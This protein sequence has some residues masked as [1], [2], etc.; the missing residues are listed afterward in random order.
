M[1]LEA[2]SAKSREGDRDVILADDAT[3]AGRTLAH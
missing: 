1:H 3:H 2:D